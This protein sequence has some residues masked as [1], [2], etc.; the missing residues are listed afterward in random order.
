M[1]R[2]RLDNCLCKHKSITVHLFVEMI[3]HHAVIIKSLKDKILECGTL[4][5][6]DGVSFTPGFKQGR[7]AA[8]VKPNVHRSA[9]PT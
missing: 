6:L 2:Q 3:E 1:M 9:F 5:W 4:T 7:D 8:V